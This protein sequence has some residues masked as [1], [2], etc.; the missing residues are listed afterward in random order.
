MAKW[1]STVIQIESRPQ[2]TASLSL[3]TFFLTSATTLFSFPPCILIKS[4]LILE[5]GFRECKEV[6]DYSAFDRTEGKCEMTMTS[7]ISTVY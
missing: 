2:A 6:I 7:I 4:R 3:L 5:N 1:Q